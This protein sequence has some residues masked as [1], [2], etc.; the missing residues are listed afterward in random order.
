M[1]LTTP[2]VK[3]LVCAQGKVQVLKAETQQ[4]KGCMKRALN[5]TG[6]CSI[7]ENGTRNARA[8]FRLHWITLEGPKRLIA[9]SADLMNLHAARITHI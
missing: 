1:W 4:K 7:A 5:E 3:E 2:K 9:R 8:C 6:A